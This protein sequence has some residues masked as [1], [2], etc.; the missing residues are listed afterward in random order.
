MNIPNKIKN[1]NS[2]GKHGNI[3]WDIIMV[4]LAT[5][6]N[7]SFYLKDFLLQPYWAILSQNIFP[8][9]LTV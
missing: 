6:K 5:K 9:L 4:L 8:M 1:P 3:T 2:I 7:K